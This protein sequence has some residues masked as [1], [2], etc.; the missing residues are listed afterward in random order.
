[1]S[2]APSIMKQLNIKLTKYLQVSESYK[3]P[4]EEIK[5]NLNMWRDIVRLRIGMLNIINMLL[6]SNFIY[7]FNTVS[8][9][10]SVSYSA[11]INKLIPKSIWKVKGPRRANTVLT[12][13]KARRLTPPNFKAYHTATIISTTGY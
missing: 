12:K 5:E 2:L 8:L 7:R 10:I 6:L 3:T 4:M 9:K 13:D 11:D 1:M